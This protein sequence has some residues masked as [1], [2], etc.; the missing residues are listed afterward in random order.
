MSES[1]PALAVPS[2]TIPI[3][4]SISA[5]AQASLAEPPLRSPRYPSSGDVAGWR[6]YVTSMDELMLAR[7]T[8]LN[9]SGAEVE[10]EHIP[11]EGGGGVFTV[12]PSDAKPGDRRVCLD[13]HGGGL[14][15]GGGECCRASGI[16]AASLYRLPTWAVDY[17][18]PPDHPYPAGL[19]DCLAAYRALLELREPNE[20]VI[21]GMS[22]GGNL[23]AA[24]ILRARDEGLPLP[25]AAIL[26][27]PELDL[28]ESGDSFRANLGVD[29][30][31]T[32]SLMPVNLLYADGHDLT[33]AYLSPLFG[34]FSTG[35][36]STLL[37]S[38]TRDLFLSNTVLMHRALR[39]AA[40]PAELHVLEAAPHGLLLSTPEGEDLLREVHA[41][42]DAVCTSS[43]KGIMAAKGAGELGP[44]PAAPTSPPSSPR[45]LPAPATRWLLPPEPRTPA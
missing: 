33:D 24:L 32:H 28:S 42:V 43:F 35:F 13:I 37:A 45:S 25:A 26:L 12:I 27:S 10:V 44:L 5:Q 39:R 6:E 8:R 16:Y 21:T 14:V 3:P 11:L 15:I 18:M 31:L 22:A 30:V 36:P 34:D 4:T 17:R 19:D 1:R 29:S 23:A 38:G 9:S 40:I 20:I 7:F 41:F 2:R